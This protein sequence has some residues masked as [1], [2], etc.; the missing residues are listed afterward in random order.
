[1]LSIALRHD[2]WPLKHTFGISRGTKTTAETVTVEIRDFA[3]DQNGRGA[4]VPYARYGETLES[5]L[6]QL[7]AL[8]QQLP[9]EIMPEDLCQY[10]AA[11]AARNALD[12][13]LHDLRAKQTGVP[14]WKS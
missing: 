14:T 9:L 8:S 5:V 4:C 1:M 12:A 13:A 10:I 2:S 3:H 6:A 11:G 7:D